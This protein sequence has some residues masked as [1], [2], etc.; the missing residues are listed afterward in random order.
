M[1]GHVQGNANRCSSKWLQPDESAACPLESSARLPLGPTWK[2]CQEEIASG[3]SG[4]QRSQWKHTLR[5]LRRSFCK[6]SALPLKRSSTFA[7]N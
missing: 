7:T 4:V 1:A 6:G 3:Q 2:M 5:N